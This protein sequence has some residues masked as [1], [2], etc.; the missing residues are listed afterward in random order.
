MI[1]HLSDFI[2]SFSWWGDL[3]KLV[4]GIATLVGVIYGV[5]QQRM[6]K[7]H[8]AILLGFLHGLKPSIQSA[9]RGEIVAPK[10]WNDILDQIHDMMSR[11]QP[12]K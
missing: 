8:D 12:P 3:S 10:L 7:N 5:Y 4:A 2:H 9:A 6:R 11:I 1:N